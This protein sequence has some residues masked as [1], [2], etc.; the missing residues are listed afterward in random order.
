[1][2]GIAGFTSISLD[3]SELNERVR[4]MTN[5]IRHRGPD[6]SGHRVFAG[7]RGL[8][9]AALGHRR[10]AIIDLSDAGLQPM[11]NED[12]TVWLVFNGEIYNYAELRSELIARGHRFR[13][14]TDSE[15]LLHLYEEEGPE[16]VKRLNGMF[17]FAILDLHQNRVVLARDHIGVKPL[18]YSAG[19]SG[20]YFGSEIKAILAAMREPPRVD[21]QAIFDY[22]TFLYIPGPQTAFEGIRQLPPAHLLVCDLEKQTHALSR[23]WRVRRMPE[24]QRAGK[25]DLEAALHEK[26]SAAVQRELVSDVPLGVF[27]SGGIDSSALAGLARQSGVAP[28]T[29]TVDFS[30]P[31]LRYYSEAATAEQTARYLGTQHQTLTVDS[32]KPGEM[33]DLIDYFD[34][35]FGNPTFYLQWLIARSSR[36]HIT[37][38][39]NGAGGD[40]LF[41]G[42]PRYRAA[43]LSR[44]FHHM[45]NSLLKA[46]RRSLGL[47]KDTNRTM[48]L[49]R[50]REFL[51][52]LDSDPV[53]EFTNWTYYMTATDKASLFGS[54]DT[55]SFSPSDRYVREV[56]DESP[57]DDDNRLLDV[58]VQTF[59]VDNLLAY[60]DRMSMAVGMEVRVPLL[61]PDFV[62]LALN[63]PFKWK[64]NRH[65]SKQIMRDAFA[66]Y[67]TPTVRAGGKRGF[68][69]PLGQWIR[70]ELDVYFSPPNATHSGSSASGDLSSWGE[71]GILSAEFIQWMRREHHSGRQD[72]SHELFAVLVFDRWWQ[73]HVRG[74]GTATEGSAGHRQTIT[75]C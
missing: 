55:S 10:L 71:N 36:E 59:L 44:V 72:L 57:F 26:L 52:G 15:V 51:D 74:G 47:F 23:Y 9:S 65:G 62:A 5:A 21:W 73:K 35:P 66:P 28:R 17:A 43:Q 4:R 45:P 8:M 31:E 69:A 24:I 14:A 40:E 61:E 38:A 46:G 68:N 1:M 48:R 33:L 49:R 18:Y 56:F 39:L 22:F 7:R 30:S 13:S 53:R 58:D 27:L 19:A 16:F 42:Y 6:G 2:C 25:P 70:R 64:L 50:I 29:Y 37:V 11:P 20:L 75:V 12:E 63:V 60:T 34:Q 54:R 3:P 32:V 67:L 41:A